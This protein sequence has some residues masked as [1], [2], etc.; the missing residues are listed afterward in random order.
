MCWLWDVW[1][2]DLSY[3]MHENWCEDHLLLILD[4]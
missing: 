1:I 4:V 3:Y 2:V